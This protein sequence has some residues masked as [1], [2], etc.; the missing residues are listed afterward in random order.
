MGV[1]PGLQIAVR[2]RGKNNQCLSFQ[3][4]NLSG[5]I[6]L[7]D[8]ENIFSVLRSERSKM[9]STHKPGSRRHPFQNNPRTPCDQPNPNG[10]FCLN[11]VPV[12]FLS[13]GAI[14]KFFWSRFMAE[15]SQPIS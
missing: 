3:I 15:N 2:E 8:Q 4:F 7:S 10:T 1:Q 13:N 12:D 14:R 11:S 9:C 5:P 6:I